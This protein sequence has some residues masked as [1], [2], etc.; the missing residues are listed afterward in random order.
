MIESIAEEFIAAL[1]KLEASRDPKEIVALYADDAQISNVVAPNKFSGPQGARDFWTKYRETFGDL[2]SEF[3]NQIYGEQSAAL[4][5]TTTGTSNSKNEICYSGVTILEIEN[6][7]ITRSCAYF[8]ADDLGR[9][10]ESGAPP[11][12]NQAVSA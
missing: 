7:K 4:E 5:W 9:Q 6:D 3:R 2:R 12:Q 1:H 8:N 10:I 11:K